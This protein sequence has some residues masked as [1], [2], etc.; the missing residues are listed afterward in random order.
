MSSNMAL[1]CR[2]FCQ[3]CLGIKLYFAGVVVAV[4]ACA[5]GVGSG[6]SAGVVGVVG[7]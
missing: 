4:R 2:H 3:R 6:G 1:H 7:L 5:G